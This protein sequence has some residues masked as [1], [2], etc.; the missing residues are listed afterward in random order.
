MALNIDTQDLVNYPGNTKRVTIDV[1]S[2]VPTGY[3]GDEQIVLTISTN[4]YSDIANTT[5]IQNLYITEAKSGWIKSSGFKGNKFALDATSTNM[6]LRLD[7]T[8]SGTSQVGGQWGYYPITLAHD[9]GAY[10]TGEAVAA[11]METKIR[12][13]PDTAGWKTADD[14][15]ILSY[16]NASVEFS[17]GKFKII[18]GSITN[19]YT[20]TN[21]SAVAV[22]S[23]TANDV[24]SS[25]GFDLTL[26]SEDIANTAVREAE[27]TTTYY[28]NAAGASH[29]LYISTGTS[30]QTGEAMAITDGINTDYFTVDGVVADSQLT[31]ASG[32]IANSYVANKAKVQLLRLGDP[33]GEPTSYFT[34]VDGLARYGLKYMVNQIDYSS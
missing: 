4:A 30:V 17:D 6:R 1:D 10:L 29:T 7:S 16:R 21:K 23:G 11:D 3:E 28:P 5:A 24:T 22:A 13:I 27:V 31:V 8:A 15:F 14:G 33:E 9:N 19:Y 18:S 34:S 32:S 25:L 20:G 26:S 2:I 12:A